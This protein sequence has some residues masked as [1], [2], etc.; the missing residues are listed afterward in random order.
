M[1][2]LDNFRFINSCIYSQLNEIANKNNKMRFSYMKKYFK[3]IDTHI[4]HL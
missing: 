4:N 1:I 3:K 2:L